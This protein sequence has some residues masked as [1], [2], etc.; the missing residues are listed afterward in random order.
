MKFRTL[1]IKEIF[2][3]KLSKEFWDAFEKYISNKMIDG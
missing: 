1:N 3:A 2:D